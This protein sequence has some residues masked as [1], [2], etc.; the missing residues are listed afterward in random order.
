MKEFSR[1]KFY[2]SQQNLVTFVRLPYRKKKVGKKL[3]V[4]KFFTDEH[5]FTR[6]FDHKLTANDEMFYRRIFY[7][8]FFT[9]K[10]SVFLQGL[11]VYLRKY[12]R[13]TWVFRLSCT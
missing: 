11:L 6:R 7:A 10:V 9:G 13:L 4:T 12:E 8:D 3:Q 1:T 5:F 2:S